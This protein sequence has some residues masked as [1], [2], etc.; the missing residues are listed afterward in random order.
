MP[1]DAP[2]TST[3]SLFSFSLQTGMISGIEPGEAQAAVHHPPSTLPPLVSADLCGRQLVPSWCLATKN[4]SAFLP[5]F[6]I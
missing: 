3:K 5:F 4:I 1:L 2:W 6:A